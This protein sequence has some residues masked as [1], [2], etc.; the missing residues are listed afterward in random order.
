MI[1]VPKDVILHYD[2][3]KRKFGDT[4]IFREFEKKYAHE[5]DFLKFKFKHK[6]KH[7]KKNGW[8][9]PFIE[10]VKTIWIPDRKNY[11]KGL[12]KYGYF[13][14]ISTGYQ[15]TQDFT[16]KKCI[17]CGNL[18]TS[19]Q[20]TSCC[21]RH[22]TY[23]GRVLKR[24]KELYGFDLK[25]NG[26]HLL[27]PHEWEISIS[28]KGNTERKHIREPLKHFNEIQFVI[29]GKRYNYTTRLRRF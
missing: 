8:N 16:N 5:I 25:K 26:H 11:H 14:N 9:K 17:W 12:K 3:L 24:G 19:K 23:L 4:E 7:S 2:E 28:E 21:D 27:I 1:S 13:A 6:L 22:R 29:N 20:I 15:L 10:N 18:L